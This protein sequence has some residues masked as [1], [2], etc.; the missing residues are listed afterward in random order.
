M[1]FI[2][3]LKQIN[4]QGEIEYLPGQKIE[5]TLSINTNDKM[6][7]QATLN[8]PFYGYE[9]QSLSFNYEGDFDRAFNS[10]AELQ[11]LLFFLVSSVLMKRF[12]NLS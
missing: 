12:E 4:T 11:V 8:T 2:S 7:A 5:S 6:T 1:M 3:L 10:R 9:K